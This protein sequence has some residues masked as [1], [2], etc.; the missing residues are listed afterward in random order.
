MRWRSPTPSKAGG[1]RVPKL[2]GPGGES[3]GSCNSGAKSGDN[4]GLEY[5]EQCVSWRKQG[6]KTVIL[7]ILFPYQPIFRNIVRVVFLT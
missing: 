6:C 4:G 7:S 3:S 5:K 1:G 2:T